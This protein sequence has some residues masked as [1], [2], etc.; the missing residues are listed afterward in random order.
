MDGVRAAGKTVRAQVSQGVLGECERGETF[1]GA[2]GICPVAERR[3]GECTQMVG[4]YD[5]A[6]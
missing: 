3:R 6:R 5:L 1:K 2:Q 4:T